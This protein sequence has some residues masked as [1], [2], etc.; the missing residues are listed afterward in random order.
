VA[1]LIG[2][3][4]LPRTWTLLKSSINVLLEGVPEDVDL[5]SVKKLILSAPGV[6]SLHDLHVWA[7]TN[8]KASLT[9]H[10]VHRPDVNA[11]TAILPFLSK[12]LAESFGITHITVQCE[13]DECHQTD[14]EHHFGRPGNSTTA[15]HDH[16]GHPNAP[17]A[18]H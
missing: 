4:V 12:H 15:K 10:V 13:L 6:R 14:E 9:A 5:E 7:L 2:L 11:E 17:G 16:D 1:I 8:G 3:W 18:H